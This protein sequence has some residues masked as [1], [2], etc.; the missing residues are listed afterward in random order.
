MFFG[1]LGVESCNLVK[2]FESLGATP[3]QIG[4]NPADWMLTVITSDN[5]NGIDYVDAFKDSS[6]Y[7]S[8]QDKIQNIIDVDGKDQEKKI[9]F[10]T[11]YAAD[12][13]T[14]RG[15]VDK[16]LITIYWRSPAYNLSRMMISVVI[17]FV[18]GSIYVTNRL[19]KKE[20][21]SEQE[22][23]G[24]LSLIFI[25]FII[26]GVMSINA[27]LPV[28]L[29]IRDSF[30]RQRAA[31]MY[32]FTSLGWALGTAEKYFIVISSALFCVVFLPCIGIGLTVARGIGFW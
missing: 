31:G 2:Y 14:R 25:S 7:Q 8:M 26:I 4:Q 3:I 12:K 16:R 23:T 6:N 10:A 30:Y 27:V 18:L 24:I 11:E 21:V 32:G 9:M 17:A 20:E 29:S 5:K 1:E 15:L 22:M 19:Y 28:M 13:S